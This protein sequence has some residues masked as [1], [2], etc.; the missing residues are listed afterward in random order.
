[1]I[2]EDVVHR[3]CELARY[4]LPPLGKELDEFCNR[5]AEQC[6]S[7]SCIQEFAAR[8]S[9]FN[10]F[11][12]RQGITT[13]EQIGE[14]HAE[15]FTAR[16]RRMHSRRWLDDTRR[17][18]GVLIRYL[19]DR[20]IL[21]PHPKAPAPYEELLDRYAQY[22]ETYRGL[23]VGT[24]R[25]YRFYLTAFIQAL[26]QRNLP[27]AI[28]DL[29]PQDVQS[30]FCKCVQG[31]ATRTRGHIR[32]GLRH[33]FA[34]CAREGYGVGHLSE[35]IP[36]VYSYRLADVPRQIPEQDAH[37]LLQSIDRSTKSGRR[38]YAMIL[39][40]YTYGVRGGQVRALRLNDI[41]WRQSRIRFPVCKGG[42][43]VVE[44]ITADVGDAL[45]D[46][47][48]NG[49]PCVA[50]PEVFL[51]H[52]APVRP[53]SPTCLYNCVCSRLRSLGLGQGARGP[54]GFRH[55]FASR[56]LGNGHSI[57]TIADMLGHR[58]INSTFIYTKVDF[59]TLTDVPLDW[60]EVKHE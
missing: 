37:R 40:L 12:R 28:T 3:P 32:A 10:I 44:P 53:L 9:Q 33:F 43:Q 31:K 27:G 22:L 7:Y 24:I 19:T 14:E 6:Y 60:P 49:R 20:G 48:R 16:R 59:R 57:K 18:L 36:H 11:L 26:D 25:N 21:K 1:M 15:R 8:V 2:L 42:R 29:A 39:V 58:D 50:W 41:H 47:L 45:L 52:H 34:F 46:Y 54:H 23:A 13:A 56:L 35:A 4:R 55:A 17:A 30:F 51:T 38:D 5:L